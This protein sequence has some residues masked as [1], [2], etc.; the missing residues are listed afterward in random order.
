MR[1]YDTLKVNFGDPNYYSA[2]VWISVEVNPFSY[3]EAF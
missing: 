3:K 1:Y 2:S